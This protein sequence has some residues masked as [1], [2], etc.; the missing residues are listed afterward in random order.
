MDQIT[1]LEFGVGVLVGKVLFGALFASP[2]FRSVAL[3]SGAAAVCL[4]YFQDGVAAI[5]S[6]AHT[7]RA[8]FAERPDFARGAIVGATVAFVVFGVHRTKR[9]P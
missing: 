2:L 1:K 7:L 3:A 8:D 9:R 6:L 5:L 4:L